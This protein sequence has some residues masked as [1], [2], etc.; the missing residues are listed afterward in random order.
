MDNENKATPIADVST[1]GGDAP[2]VN[3]EAVAAF[4]NRQAREAEAAKVADLNAAAPKRGRGRPRQDDRTTFLAATGEQVAEEERGDE[5]ERGEPTP[6]GQ[7]V[8]DDGQRPTSL[9]LGVGAGEYQ[10]SVS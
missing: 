2:A 7:G 1:L 4:K 9:E 10:F 8:E 3:P 6:G 5:H